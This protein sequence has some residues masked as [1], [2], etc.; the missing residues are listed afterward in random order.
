MREASMKVIKRNGTSVKMNFNKITL[1]LEKLTYGL[2][3]T[4]DIDTIT[5]KIIE[6]IYDGIKTTEL[7]TLGSE[8]ATS[9]TSTH[10]DYAILGARI[11]LSN[12][13]K[14]TLKSFSETMEL[15]YNDTDSNG[16][17]R[18]K[19]SKE[20][21]EFIRTHSLA[22]DSE[23][24]H[25]RDFK[26][27]FFGFKTLERSY[28]FR[29][30]NKIVET[31][32]FMFMRVACQNSNWDLDLALKLYYHL[33]KK[34]FILATPNLFNS[35]TPN[36]QM[37]SCFLL[38]IKGDSI[39]S[40]FDTVKDCALISKCAGGIGLDITN[41][42][43]KGSHIH[44]TNGKSNGIVPMLRVF[45]NTALYVDQ[46]GN[47][48]PGSF[49]MYIEPWH[50]DIEDFLTLRLPHK[51]ENLRAL[52]LFYGLWIPD[53][54][55]KCVESNSDWYLFCPTDAP[56]LHKT[57]G[58]E[59]E[60]LYY[61][62]VA[63]KKYR[64]VIKAQ[65]LFK[66]ILKS[67]AETGTPYMLYKDSVNEK[68]NQKNIGMINSSNLCCEIV[69][70]TSPEEIAVCNLASI[71]LPA[72]YNEETGVYDYERLYTVART[73]T[74]TLNTVIDNNYYPVPEARKSNLRH[75]PIGIGVQ[76]LANVFAMAKISF[77]SDTARVM[78]RT[79]FETIYFA[80]LTESC[81]MAKETGKYATFD[82]SPAS[83]GIL[84]PDMWENVEYSG[85]WDFEA[86]R[87]E[88]KT[89]GLKNS[90][91]IAPMPTASTSQILGNNECFEPFTNNLYTRSVLSGNF[92]VLSKYLIKDLMD[93]KLWNNKMRKRIMKEQGSVQAIDSIP[94]D[95][96]SRYKTVWE[97][98]QRDLI[99]MAADRAPFIDQSQ[100]L[101]IFV[102]TPTMANLGAIHMH[103]WKKGLKTGM[104]Y[105]RTLS[106]SKAI[107][108]TNQ[109]SD[110]EDDDVPDVPDVPDDII[111]E[112]LPEEE[113][114]VCRI[115]N[116]DC[117][118]CGS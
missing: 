24:V 66:H 5:M 74:R 118:A 113:P 33:S 97:T 56:G 75:R 15:L 59:F 72:F 65:D 23:I 84:Q 70:H 51:A 102:K 83:M 76:G 29:I 25:D 9:M 106:Q 13:K 67:Q 58:K 71:S 89:H 117:E 80:A 81:Q 4:L 18:P 112:S 17:P 93:L 94:D 92:Q 53:L 43:A 98:S 63:Q 111:K 37:S 88:I 68:S 73:V 32:Q 39:S 50:L 11:G 10:P 21:I 60:T 77:T 12:L 1:R 61:D 57:Y 45:N 35:C 3:P 103:T 20:A 64:K 87:D 54:F 96:K 30:G 86:L 116:P 78:N 40:I 27:D 47:K 110:S 101:N 14:M 19:L 69:Q 100:S 7:D 2:D 16:N 99:D 90:L 48:R 36:P 104:Y 49:A 8:I 108:F 109:D 42:R 107:Q 26:F 105:L 114:L 52:D 41:I 46:G 34:E 62:L 79:I 82:G 95:L 6:N 38:Q 115:D 22:L 28:L 55:M 44:G 31:P 91:M 85:L